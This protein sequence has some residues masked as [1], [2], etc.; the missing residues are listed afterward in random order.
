MK[1]QQSA[2]KC[3]RPYM[4]TTQRAWPSSAF[5]SPSSFDASLRETPQSMTM[6]ASARRHRRQPRSQPSAAAQLALGL[7]GTDLPA[8]GVPWSYRWQPAPLPSSWPWSHCR[9]RKMAVMLWFGRR[10]C[11]AA[12]RQVDTASFAH[13]CRHFSVCQV[14]QCP[15][16]GLHFAG[17]RF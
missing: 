10:F 16:L 3:C 4:D 8:F 11:K 14:P 1:A 17:A 12:A 13:L 7:H 5:G 9:Q 2:P 15:S 6:N